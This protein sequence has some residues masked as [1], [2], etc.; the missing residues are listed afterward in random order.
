MPAAGHY[1]HQVIPLRDINP[2]HSRPVL[3]YSLIAINV[4]V[5]VYQI[6]LGEVAMQEFVERFGVVP[7]FLTEGDML[8]LRSQGGSLGS[9]ITPVTSMFMH[10]GF[11]HIIGNMWFL[12]VFGDNIEDRIGSGR[13][14]V[15][16]LVCGLAAVAAQV[17]VDPDSRIPMVGAS[18]AIAG[19]L[20][21]AAVA[22]GA[23]RTGIVITVGAALA[24]MAF[25]R[26]VSA[27]LDDR[28]AFYPNWFYFLV[29]AVA[30]AAL[31]IAN[32]AR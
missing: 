5:F 28:T 14:A 8:G 22:G 4:A 24:G 13:Y 12:H 26:L 16:Y 17:V 6:T 1:R 25:G 7:Y 11:L 15:F 9:W 19:V 29:E 27:V 2:T 20:G 3:T 10:G 32:L 18:G 21:Y 23:I 30:A 31:F